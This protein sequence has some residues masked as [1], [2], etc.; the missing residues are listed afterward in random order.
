MRTFQE[1]HNDTDEGRMREI[2]YER[3]SAKNGAKI[4]LSTRINLLR[5]NQ[6]SPRF[7]TSIRCCWT[8][9]YWRYCLEQGRF[10]GMELLYLGPIQ[11]QIHLCLI[12]CR[13]ASFL[14][15]RLNSLLLGFH[16]KDSHYYDR[17]TYR[18][19]KRTLLVLLMGLKRRFLG[20]KGAY[21]MQP[22]LTKRQRKGTPSHP[23]VSVEIIELKTLCSELDDWQ[24]VI[25]KEGFL[26][27][28]YYRNMASML[29]TSQ[30][31]SLLEFG[32][33][34]PIFQWSMPSNVV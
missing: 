1:L 15:A 34:L 4:L 18:K 11:R 17:A 28:I 30:S 5:H 23:I 32:S 3:R 2:N 12:R 14:M 9:I 22:S 27:I 6:F 21:K 25:H 31:K 33:R 16:I 29:Q 7:L 20:I 10:V 19:N 8:W 24:G 26:T 13:F